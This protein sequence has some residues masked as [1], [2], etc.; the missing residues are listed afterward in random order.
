MY[1]NEPG[2]YKLFKNCGRESF[3]E[4]NVLNSG[5]DPHEYSVRKR[6]SMTPHK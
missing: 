5:C 4:C 1:F 6:N 2:K 3:F